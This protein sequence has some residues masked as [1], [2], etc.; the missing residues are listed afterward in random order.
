MLHGLDD[1]ST[2]GAGAPSRCPDETALLWAAAESLGTE[3]LSLKKQ[4]MAMFEEHRLLLF[5]YEAPKA[6]CSSAT[7]AQGDLAKIID[8][9]F[10]A[11]LNVTLRDPQKLRSG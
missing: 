10:P 2:G 3:A 5:K 7:G 6:R 11:V 1:G 9:S 8:T 4:A